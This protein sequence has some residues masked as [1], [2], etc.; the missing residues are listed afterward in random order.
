MQVTDNG[1]FLEIVNKKPN[2]QPHYVL[3]AD[4]NEIEQEKQKFYEA[5]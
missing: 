3:S 5:A 4:P 1:T 2:D